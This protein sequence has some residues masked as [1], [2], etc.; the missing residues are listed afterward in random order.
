MNGDFLNNEYI[1]IDS[2]I[3]NSYFWFFPVSKGKEMKIDQYCLELST[4]MRWIL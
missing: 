1:M 3:L 2:W 4:Q